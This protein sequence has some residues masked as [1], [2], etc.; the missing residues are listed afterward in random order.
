MATNAPASD[1]ARALED[2]LGERLGHPD[3]AHE[4]DGL[5]PSFVVSPRTVEEVSALLAAVDTHDAAVIPW[6]GGLHIGLGN[7][8]SRY[9]VALRM[10]ALDGVIEYEPA[11]LV[12]TVQAGITIGALQLLLA[13]QGQ[14][15]PIDAPAAATVGGVLAA[16]VSGPSRHGYGLPRDWLLGCRVVHAGGSVTKGGGRVVKNVAGYDMPKLCIGSLGTLGVIVE[17]T[18]KLSP[19]PSVQRTLLLRFPSERAVFE[20]ISEAGRLGLALRAVV[21]TQPAQAAFWLAGG[22][23][24]VQ[25]SERELLRLAGDAERERLDRLEA[26]RWWSQLDERS[27]APE[28]GLSLRVSLPPS[29]VFGFSERLAELARDAK[30][31]LGIDSYVSTGL[32]LARLAEASPERL[33]EVVTEARR[34]ASSA[35]GSL[36]VTE[37]PLAVKEHIDVWGAVGDAGPLMQRLKREFDPRGI[38]SPGRYLAGV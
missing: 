2:I 13:A 30:L 38:L 31:E 6:G 1:V 20:A 27:R 3:A 12:V 34:A 18:F 29:K 15:L 28:G 14:F 7:A 10:G 21:A 17:A 5:R 22:D 11:D 33:A 16:G 4:V 25:R 35:G 9:D 19:L 26:D 24:A 37:A 32:L 36:V 23:A 8:P